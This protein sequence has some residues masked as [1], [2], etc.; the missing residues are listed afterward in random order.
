LRRCEIIQIVTKGAS[1]PMV[2]AVWAAAGGGA[3]V[4][5]YAVWQ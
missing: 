2:L 1:N 3:S 5:V 4:L